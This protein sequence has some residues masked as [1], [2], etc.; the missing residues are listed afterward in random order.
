MIGNYKVNGSNV[1]NAGNFQDFC[2]PHYQDK[3]LT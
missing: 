1:K 3:N 2:F